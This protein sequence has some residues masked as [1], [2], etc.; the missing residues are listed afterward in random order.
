MSVFKKRETL[1]QN[2]TY[3]AIMAAINV[4]FVVLTTLVPLL[5]F[6]IIFVLP[7]T[8]TV[9]A[10]FCKKKYYTNN[11]GF[12]SSPITKSDRVAAYL[13]LVDKLYIT[14]SRIHG[15]NPIVSLKTLIDKLE[16]QA[17]DQYNFVDIEDYPSYEEV[18][19]SFLERVKLEGEYELDF[20]VP[21]DEDRACLKPF[22]RHYKHRA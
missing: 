3:M 22:Y 17:V 16:Q 19:E 13:H 7:L 14:L 9:V 12:D 21:N 20:S 11:V 10:L 4:V 6:L 8:S 2:I 5:M 1:I 18:Y 15:A